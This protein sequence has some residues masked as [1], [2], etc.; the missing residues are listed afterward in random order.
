[1]LSLVRIAFCG[2]S[3]L[4]VP[5]AKVTDLTIA[6]LA[7]SAQRYVNLSKAPRTLRAYQSDWTDFQA[8]CE[9]QGMTCL[10]A[11]PETV[12]L[13]LASLADQNRKPATISRRLAAISKMHSAKGY[14]SPAA[15]RHAG[16]KEVWSGIRRSK[17]MAQN[18]KAAAVT[19][20]LK[21]MLEQIPDSLIGIRDRALLLVGFTGALRRSELVA[22]DIQSI[23]FVAEGLVL[24]IPRS[25]TD[26]EGSGEKIAIAPGRMPATCPIRSLHS[27]LRVSGISSGPVFRSITRHQKISPKALTDQVVALQVKRYAGAAGL[28]PSLFSGH[29]LRAG[30]ATSAAIAGAS[31]RR[32]QDRTRH[33]S[34]VMVRRYIRDG[35]LFR[36]NVSGLVGL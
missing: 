2:N 15:M 3:L 9:G 26:Q 20:Y 11:Q 28:D 19:E 21:R 22:L 18:A 4:P 33:R 36:D 16:V 10:P 23:Q 7:N 24:T 29:S 30:L 6:K 31:E 8:F 25:K 17:G 13:Y 1:M 32:I 34:V 12:A 5:T 35:N 27:C 14:D